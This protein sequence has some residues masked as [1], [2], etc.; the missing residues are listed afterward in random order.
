MTKIIKLIKIFLLIF[1]TIIGIFAIN[2]ILNDDIKFS[3]KNI[4]STEK[5]VVDTTFVDTKYNYEFED[6]SELVDIDLQ[7][8]LQKNLQQV[9]PILKHIQG[10]NNSE[11]EEKE[12]FETTYYI[13]YTNG[14]TAQTTLEKFEK[15][16]KGDIVIIKTTIIQDK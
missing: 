13:V 7:K 16:K 11:C 1:V 4:I 3:N 8:N 10:Y 2:N 12:I 15:I 9:Q 6:H 5:K 14:D